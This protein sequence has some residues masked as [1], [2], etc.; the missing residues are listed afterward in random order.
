MTV[1]PTISINFDA[2]ISRHK[3]P[4]HTT[5]P[6]DYRPKPTDRGAAILV[7]EDWR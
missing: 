5:D 2:G 7:A 4:H 3:T 6:F 1:Q